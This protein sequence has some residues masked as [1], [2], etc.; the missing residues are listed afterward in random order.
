MLNETPTLLFLDIDGVLHPVS[1]RADRPDAESQGFSYRPRLE[2]VLR[3]FPDVQIVIAS[4]WRKYHTL[5]ELQAFFA[6]DIA[7]RVISVT[8]PDPSSEY[9]PR[10][11]QLRVE[12]WLKENGRD[13]DPW[14]A[15]DDDVSN[16]DLEANL[17]L[18]NDG[19]RDLEECALREVLSGKPNL[20]S[21]SG[22]ASRR[23]LV[24]LAR[25]S[26]VAFHSKERITVGSMTRATSHACCPTSWIRSSDKP[27]SEIW[28][29]KWRRANS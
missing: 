3:E 26:C 28:R 20:Y 16:Y 18:C 6:P 13:G 7:A 15:I 9:V 10:R 29:P 4:D 27:C 12:E 2:R 24:C 21:P 25:S 11:R 5:G 8:P 1:P 23:G 19:F 22:M 14:V 17:V